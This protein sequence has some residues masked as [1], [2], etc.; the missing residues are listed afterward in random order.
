MLRTGH[1]IWQSDPL[2]IRKLRMTK[3]ILE[4]TVFGGEDSN[5]CSEFVPG[6]SNGYLDK[7][8]LECVWNY[9]YITTCN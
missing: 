9:K 1:L 3:M 4:F 8:K 7:S 6:Y 5:L 2:L